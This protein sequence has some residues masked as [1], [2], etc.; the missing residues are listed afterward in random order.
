MCIG[1]LSALFA[2]ADKVK[3]VASDYSQ[4]FHE[5]ADSAAA[6]LE[7]SLPEEFVSKLE[8]ALPGV[9]AQASIQLQPISEAATQPLLLLFLLLLL[10]LLMLLL[11]LLLLLLL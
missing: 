1:R 9:A 4:A 3:S 8:P 6:K 10:L 2:A 7:E 5:F 11:L